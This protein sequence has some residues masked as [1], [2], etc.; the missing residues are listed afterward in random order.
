MPLQTPPPNSEPY[1]RVA[2][3]FADS[4]ARAVTDSVSDYTVVV[5]VAVQDVIGVEV[6][7]WS[8]PDTGAV[9]IRKGLNS[10]FD[11]TVFRLL[12]SL[13]LETVTISVDLVDAL[14]SGEDELY[15]SSA[16]GLAAAI[17]GLFVSLLGS[18]V[19]TCTLKYGRLLFTA[20]D[21]FASGMSLDFAS[22]ARATTSAHTALGWPT[23]VDVVTAVSILAPALPQ[24]LLFTFITVSVAEV[25]EY[26]PLKRIYVGRSDTSTVRTDP[27]IS[28]T[29]LLTDQPLRRMPSLH[30]SVRMQG[31]YELED[32][33]DHHLTFTVF[34]LANET[35]T[36]AWARKQAWAI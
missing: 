20:E 12:P 30:V 34:S 1:V 29:R 4:A 10:G 11:A 16:S 2:R 7:G 6:T 28:R 9:T 25:A 27:G 8:F 14:G 17:N 22:G 21:G 5:P 24:L 26:T 3:V 31:L 23:K 15:Y 35:S 18:S 19:A 32:T 36:P 13:A 33:F